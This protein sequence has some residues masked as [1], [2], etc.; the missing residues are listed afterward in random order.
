MRFCAWRAA[1]SCLPDTC[2]NASTTKKPSAHPT[3]PS[4]I[5]SRVNSTPRASVI[6]TRLPCEKHNASQRDILLI[7]L[8]SDDHGRLCARGV[9]KFFD[10]PQSFRC[11]PSSHASARCLKRH[12]HFGIARICRDSCGIARAADARTDPREDKRCAWRWTPC[13]DR[14]VKDLAAIRL[15]HIISGS[16]L[17]STNTSGQPGLRHTNR[18]RGMM[19]AR[20]PEC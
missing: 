3:V 7:S 5:Q 15:A 16:E 17:R 13:E 1:R 9:V 18:Q 6:I 8:P 19:W 2:I 12:A 10:A 14:G 11:G 20:T 4:T